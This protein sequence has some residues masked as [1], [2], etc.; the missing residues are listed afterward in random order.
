MVDEKDLRERLAKLSLEQKVALLTGADFWTLNPEPAIGLR[1]ITVSDGPSGVRGTRWDERDTSLLFPNPSALSAT[2]DPEAA[3]EAGRLMGAQ[4]RKMGV[5]V[6]LAPTINLHRSPL[7]G[8]HFECYSEDPLLTAEITRGF[9]RGVQSA[10]VGATLK[11]Y[12]GNESETDRMTYDARIGEKDLRELYL[13][14]FEAVAGEAWLVMAAYN[15][16]NGHTMTENRR[17]VA[18]VLK[19]EWGF[20]GVVISDWFAARSTE[21]AAEGGLDLVM[22]GPVG[23]WGDRLVE[24]VRAGAVAEEIVDDKVLRVLRLAARVGALEGVPAPAPAPLPEDTHA[25]MR[26]LAGRAAVLLRNEG[27]LLPL[28]GVTKVALIGPNAVRLSAQGGG[29]AHVSPEYEVSPERGLRRALGDGVDIEVR[30]GVYSHRILP[31]LPMDLA[32]DP[33]TGENGV[34]VDFAGEDGQVIASETRRSTRLVFMGDLPEGTRRVVLRTTFAVGEG[35]EHEFSVFGVG[36]YVLRV[37]GQETEVALAVDTGDPIEGLVRPPERRVRAALAAGETVDLAL[38]LI[39][40]PGALPLAT[41]GLGYSPPRLDEDAELAAAV[42]A[43]KEADVAIVV[44][45]TNDDVESEGF[46]RTGLALPGRQDELVERVAAANPRTVVV[47]NAGSPV[48]MPW[49]DRVPALLWGWLP[50]QEGGNALADVLTGAIEPGGRLPTTYPAAEEDSPVLSTRPVDGAID[51]SERFGYPVYGSRGVRPAFP[52]GFGLGYTTWEYESLAVE[53]G[54]GGGVVAE[55]TV[56]NSGERAGREI[57]QVYLDGGARLLGFA[58]VEAGPGERVTAR[59]EV[60]ARALST[61][62]EDGW[63][64]PSGTYTISAGRSVADLPLTAEV[65]L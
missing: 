27:G 33:E 47:L 48:L 6:L 13:A 58:P 16:V 15:G 57:V 7:G 64:T 19:G 40:E 35:G 12:V 21:A 49:A 34:R 50:G 8:R 3:R 9:V 36:R 63:S 22:P 46:D 41:I 11:H 39:H 43:A 38:T 45:G 18:D 31:T 1:K 53:A 4:A 17:L 25:R 61:W 28:T 59:V 26:R 51:Y 42:A 44:V 10:G 2:W 23:P 5:D 60:P 20:D 24:A 62:E 14:P 65:T 56:R 29:S 52:F 30:E 37:N 32:R 54:P 55:V